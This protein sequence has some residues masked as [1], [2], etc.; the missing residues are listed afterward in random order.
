MNGRPP[1]VTVLM[2]VRNGE[3]FIRTALE[4]VLNQTYGDFLFRIVDDASTDGTREVIRSIRDERVELTSLEKNVGQ[5]AALNIGLKRSES[6]WIARM[7][8][9]DW[10]AATRLE[11]QRAALQEDPSLACVGTGVWEFREDPQ[12]RGAVILRPE[13]HADIQRASLLGSGMIHGSILVSRRAL[14][15]IG[16]YDERYR[17]ASDRDLFIRLFSR[18]RARNIP[19]PLLGIRRHAGQDSFS[20]AAADEYIQLFSRFLLLDGFAPNDKQTLRES[21]AYSHLFRAS[22]LRRRGDF[23][24]GYGEW[25]RALRTSPKVV[26]RYLLGRVGAFL[27]PDVLRSRWSE[28]RLG[29]RYEPE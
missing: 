24:E 18:Y 12:K 10:S 14:L 13:R 26:A 11:E 29:V 28:R 1:S 7:D 19:K 6:P 22:C 9:D 2:A 21:L 25:R 8:A 23:I 5:T 4:S 27:I 16:G 20:L 15:D 3:R 17:Y